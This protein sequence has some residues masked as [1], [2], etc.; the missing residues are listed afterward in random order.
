MRVEAIRAMLPLLIVRVFMLITGFMALYPL[1]TAQQVQLNDHA[2]FFAKTSS[3]Y[4]GLI[5]VIAGYYF[6]GSTTRTDRGTQTDTTAEPPGCAA[7]NE[8]LN[9]RGTPTAGRGR[10]IPHRLSL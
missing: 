3:V 4:I 10:L 7:Q 1:L 8:L 6:G 5:G 9:D 2:D